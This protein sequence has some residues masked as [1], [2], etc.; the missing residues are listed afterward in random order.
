LPARGWQPIVALARGRRFHD[1][2]AYRAAHPNFETVEVDGLLGTRESRVA[3]LRETMRRIRPDL[4]VPINI[5]DT[6]EAVAREK[7]GGSK[8]RLLV[9]L[10]AIR[11][12]GE[13][14]DIRRW[15]DF[16]DV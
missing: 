13:L 3:A 6:L 8:S 9:M 16:I 7:A 15:R 5:A 11:P 2:A 10:R 4:V 14:E 12:H 1:P